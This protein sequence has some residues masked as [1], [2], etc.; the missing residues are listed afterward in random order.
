MDR[1]LESFKHFL[2]HNQS[3][4]FEIFFQG[5]SHKNFNNLLLILLTSPDLMTVLTIG[6]ENTIYG[7]TLF[8]SLDIRSENCKLHSH[9]L[10]VSGHTGV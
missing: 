5:D 10:S 1:Y 9:M 3:K 7:K 4:T 6:N 2:I 8:I